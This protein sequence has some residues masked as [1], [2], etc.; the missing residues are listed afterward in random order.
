MWHSEITL[1]FQTL[2]HKGSLVKKFLIF[3]ALSTT[4]A[5]A[6]EMP[7][8]TVHMITASI[9]P[10]EKVTEIVDGETI[11]RMREYKNSE[12]A[13]YTKYVYTHAE[14]IQIPQGQGTR[15]KDVHSYLNTGQKLESVLLH[16]PYNEGRLYSS[17]EDVS[18]SVEPVATF[19]S[20]ITR[21]TKLAFISYLFVPTIPQ[22]DG[23]DR[24]SNYVAEFKIAEL[25]GLKP[26]GITLTSV[27]PQKRV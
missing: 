2:K 11:E 7:V 15:I 23:I 12:D 3:S 26:N 8:L 10:A 25:R 27:L 24:R 20:P 6:A 14:C 18:S 5:Y 4:C 21:D 16:K 9:P 1:L 19:L 17:G 13:E 22:M